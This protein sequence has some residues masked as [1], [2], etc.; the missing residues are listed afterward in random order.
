MLCNDRV[1]DVKEFVVLGERVRCRGKLGGGANCKLGSRRHVGE[2]RENMASEC[3]VIWK[4][5]LVT[6]SVVDV[7]SILLDIQCEGFLLMLL[8][9][10][11]RQRQ[12]AS[13]RPYAQCERT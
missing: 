10:G 7:R 13:V 5:I 1:Q 11:G 8:R 12:W 4:D 9:C 2:K 6:L 3:P